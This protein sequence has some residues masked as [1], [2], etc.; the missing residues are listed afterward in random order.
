MELRHAMYATVQRAL[1]MTCIPWQ[2]CH[3]EDRGDGILVVLPPEIPGYLLL[4]PLAHHLGALLRT[5]NLYRSELAR[6]RMR[7]A[8]TAGPV[9]WDEYGVSGRVV[10]ELFRLL[11]APSF[12]EAIDLSGADLGLLAGER[13]FED[14]VCSGPYVERERYRA[15]K[16]ACKETK[17]V[18]W[19][20]LS[21]SGA[22]AA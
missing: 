2:A 13:L 3:A 9:R 8:V 1:A 21:R 11:E 17:A 7:V 10:I 14:V 6:L 19:L 18:G 4:D 20:W 15:V 12:K 22:V 16:V 5:W